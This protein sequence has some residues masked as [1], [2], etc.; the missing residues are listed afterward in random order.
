M[1]L[2]GGL[3]GD[4]PVRGIIQSIPVRTSLRTSDGKASDYAWLIHIRRLF[5]VRF[6]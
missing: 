1:A 6:R 3:S 5:D 4:C 2:A